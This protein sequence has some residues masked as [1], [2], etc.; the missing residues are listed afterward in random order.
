MILAISVVSPSLAFGAVAN[1]TWT[2]L[3]SGTYQFTNIDSSEDGQKVIAVTTSTN[4]KVIY[5]S[6]GGSTFTNIA[7]TRSTGTAA[8][9]SAVA[10]SGDGSVAY[11]TV[12]SG[13]PTSGSKVYKT[14]NFS[15]WA[16]L[17]VGDT[18]AYR[19][20]ATNTDGS[21]VIIGSGTTVKIS[22]DGGS[23]WPT[24]SAYGVFGCDISSSGQKMICFGDS[25]TLKF[26]SDYGVTWASRVP[27][28]TRYL[29]EDSAV[30]SGDG[31]TLYA[32]WSDYGGA[33]EGKSKV[34]KSTNDGTTWTEITANLPEAA[35]NS[36]TG[37]RNYGVIET[38]NNGSVVLVGSRGKS[39]IGS[40]Q[41]GYLYLSDDSG[42]S[43]TKQTGSGTTYWA[44]VATNSNG[45]K[46]FG[47]PGLD[48][49]IAGTIKGAGLSIIVSSS[50]NALTIAGNASTATYRVPIQVTANVS[51]AGRVTF[52]ADGKRI[53]GCIQRL[54][55]GTSPN[56]VATCSYSPSKRGAIRISASLD[57]TDPLATNSVS[58]S[59][60]ILVSH[61][62]SQR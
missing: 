24:S 33:L 4:E 25:S 6:D 61:R 5:S 59:A 40:Y 15:T 18:G 38:S 43:W 30:I 45:S 8:S 54:T 23:T 14:T 48:Y 27:S 50:F 13:G 35:A 34:Y 49:T 16:Q 17:S 1:L 2:T 32:I 62:N 46:L 19:T 29:F 52:Y 36:N 58:D 53:G 37:Y 28:G 9:F 11:L 22:S 20:I 39:T 12:D 44:S 31:S 26:S 42:V 55:S 60:R 10:I 57:P 3:S 56:I 21:V 41:S 51:T 7:P 47:A